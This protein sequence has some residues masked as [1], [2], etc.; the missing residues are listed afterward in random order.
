MP[1]G[2]NDRGRVGAKSPTVG[3][4]LIGYFWGKVVPLATNDRGRDDAKSPIVGTVLIWYFGG[5]LVPM[6]EGEP[7]QNRYCGHRLDRVFLGRADATW[8]QWPRES[9]CQISYCGHRLDRVF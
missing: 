1:L 9:R 2:T 7:V 5:E 4:A 3:T 6:T 8:S